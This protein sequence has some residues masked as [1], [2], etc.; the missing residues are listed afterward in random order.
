MGLDLLSDAL[1]PKPFKISTD[2]IDDKAVMRFGPAG[3]AGTAASQALKDIK[4][5]TP[6]GDH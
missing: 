2:L 3:V 4:N 5:K 6:A 1:D